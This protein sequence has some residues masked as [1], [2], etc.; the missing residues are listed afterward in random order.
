MRRQ[1]LLAGLAGAAVLAGSLP[2]VHAETKVNIPQRAKIEAEVKDVVGG[3]IAADDTVE[4]DKRFSEIDKLIQKDKAN[5]ALR[6]PEFWVEAMQGNYFAGKSRPSTKTKVVVEEELEIYYVDGSRG[7]VPIAYLG[8]AAYQKSRP[9]PLVVT[10]LP[11][12][13]NPKE[14]IEA[15]W[16]ADETASKNWIV[17]AVAESPK[18]RVAEQP[19][20]A[21]YPFAFMREKYNTDGNRWFLEGVGDACGAAQRAACEVLPDRLA[22]LV[23]RDPKAAATNVNSRF[24][25]TYVLHAE[26]DDAVAKAYTEAVGEAAV[27]AVHGE[28]DV[29]ALAQWIDTHAPRRTLASYEFQTATSEQGITSQWTGTLWLQSPNRRGDPIHVKV[30]YDRA[31]NRV[32]VDGENLGEFHLYLNDDLVDLDNAVTIVCNGQELVS[33]KFERGLKLLFDTADNLGDYGRVFTARYI[34]NAPTVI[35]AADAGAGGGDTQPGDPEKK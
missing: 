22:G 24:F 35:A 3:D 34:G 8:A 16:K 11:A 1:L 15:N 27:S 4:R 31:T 19:H 23:L 7:T 32:T 14:W 9:H 5:T 10:L 2:R 21:T 20:L 13:T 17:A 25:G 26:G 12:G 33:K 28:G 6:T 29:A 18:F 30:Q